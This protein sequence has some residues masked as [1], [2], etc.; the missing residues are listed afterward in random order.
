MTS[1][2]ALKPGL[3][4]IVTAGASGIGYT[5]ATTLKAGGAEVWVCDISD[6]AIAR[7]QAAHPDIPAHNVDIADRAQVDAFFDTALKALGG[8]DVLVNNSGIAGPT[9]RIEDIDPDAW[10]RTI[11][12]NLNG[13]FYAARK[14]VP[15]LRAAGE[16]AIINISSCLLYTSP[17]PRDS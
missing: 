2:I 11:A 12:V 7:F 14:A 8:L 10:D 4:T 17:S 16:G 3:R 1:A 9:A 6:D 5:I 13:Q 15:A